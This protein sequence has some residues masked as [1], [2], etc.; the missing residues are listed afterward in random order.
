[1]L[2][3]ARPLVAL[4][5]VLSL[6]LPAACSEDSETDAARPRPTPTVA[7]VRP[8]EQPWVLP[9]GRLA[10][11]GPQPPAVSDLRYEHVR[12]E[13]PAVGR[14]SAISVGRGPTV[15]VLLHQTNGD[16]WCGWLP[17]LGA[18]PD[19][20]VRFLAVDLCRYGASDCVKVES[21]RFEAE[22][23]TDLV[24]VAVDHARTRMG[25][26]RVVL[27]GASMGG[28]VALMGASTLAGIDAVVD[29]SGPSDWPGAEVVRRGR[30]VRVPVLVAMAGDEGP[31]E[32]AAARAVVRNAPGGSRL[33][34]VA[35]G[36][37]YELLNDDDGRPLAFSRAVLRW[38]VDAG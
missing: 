2:I 25:A 36:H 31:E 30:A 38:I 32:V 1:M 5:A 7:S 18:R 20:A 13:D 14:S 4:A 23:Q 35:H 33:H 28:S 27:M 9:R 37:G 21:G 26:R 6:G 3:L 29:L 19:A 16:G 24:R 15:V 17:F 22:D 11:C 34:L 8:T 10:R 12:L